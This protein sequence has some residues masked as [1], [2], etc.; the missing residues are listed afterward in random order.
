M[1][2]ASDEQIQDNAST[3]PK[4]QSLT[5]NFLVQVGGDEEEDED[6]VGEPAVVT[7]WALCVEP[8]GL[9]PLL[10]RLPPLP[11]AFAH[12]KRVRRTGDAAKELPQVLVAAGCGAA[13]AAALV[14]PELAG[15]LEA[16]HVP[17]R[18]APS[19]ARLSVWTRIWP[20]TARV[21][22]PEQQEEDRAGVRER[23]ARL[24]ERALH[25]ATGG[26]TCCLLAEPDGGLVAAARA[27]PCPQ[28][29]GL[30][31]AAL[32]A[33]QAVSRGQRRQQLACTGLEVALAQEPCL[34]CAMA[35]LHSRIARLVY[36]EPD[37]QHGALG[38]RLRLHALSPLNH[39]FEVFRLRRGPPCPNNTSGML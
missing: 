3:E 8:R 36:A 30:R 7:G 6:A 33:V 29:P 26:A 25:E 12:L 21:R 1:I 13:E 24:L 17:R 22:S 37:S 15:E 39:H 5:S 11:P 31:H 23:L 16:V 27:P 10:R 9:E 19:P 14:G 18:A 2:S 35:L 38:S 28:A 32:E 34:L 4:V 20:C